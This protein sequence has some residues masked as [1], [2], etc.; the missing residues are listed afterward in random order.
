MGAAARALRAWWSGSE[1]VPRMLLV[2]DRSWAPVAQGPGGRSAADLLHEIHPQLEVEEVAEEGAR[3]GD[4]LRQ[5][6]RARHAHYPFAL[7]V[8]GPQEVARLSKSDGLERVAEEVL[9]SL[10][11]LADKVAVVQPGDLR[12]P[13]PM[14]WPLERWVQRRARWLRQTLVR[15]ARTH[16]IDC[17]EW[18]TPAAAGIS[19]PV[20]AVRGPERP[21]GGLVTV[22]WPAGLASP[23]SPR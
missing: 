2:G 19:I 7:L 13:A 3:L 15:L 20:G 22:R 12:L 18:D 6:A 21:L 11:Q 14:A 17:I 16:G 10:R 9:K 8:V 23:L 4:A 5:L 1:T